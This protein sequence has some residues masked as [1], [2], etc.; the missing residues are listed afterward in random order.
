VLLNGLDDLVLDFRLR[1]LWLAARLFKRTQF[2]RPLEP[3]LDAIQQKRIAVFV[4]LWKEHRVIQ[5]M[6]E[7]NIGANRYGNYDFFIGAY[8]NDSHNRGR[9]GSQEACKNVRSP[10]ARTTVQPQKPTI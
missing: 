10:C 2:R 6:V 8:P 9:P 5:R 7:H 4:P 3:E 1:L